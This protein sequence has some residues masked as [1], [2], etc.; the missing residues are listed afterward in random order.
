MPA[1][2]CAP[3]TPATRNP[4]PSPLHVDFEELRS[5]VHAAPV[6]HEQYLFDRRALLRHCLAPEL[7]MIIAE[8]CA[9]D[10]SGTCDFSRLRVRKKYVRDLLKNYQNRHIAQRDLRSNESLSCL[11]LDVWPHSISP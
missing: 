9:V 2:R 3:G 10:R 11:D 4:A 5:L 7:H 6:Y 8:A 1:R